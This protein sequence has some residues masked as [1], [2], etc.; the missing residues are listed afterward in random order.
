L[1]KNSNNNFFYMR[2]ALNLAKKGLGFVSPNPCVGA[3][4]V[5]DDQIIGQGYHA[6]AGDDHA[7]VIAINEAGS[8]AKD[9]YLRYIGALQSSWK[10]TTLRRINCK[11]RH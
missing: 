2:E 11:V 10:D 3:V 4:L 9:A 7:E 1:D 5:K 8:L 6:Q